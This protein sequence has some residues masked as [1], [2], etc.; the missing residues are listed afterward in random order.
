APPLFKKAQSKDW[1]FLRLKIM[2]FAIR[3]NEPR[4]IDSPAVP[5]LM[6]SLNCK[7]WAFLHLEF[8]GSP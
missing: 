3:S 6:R 2:L 5:P 7:I 8:I 4:K 1:A